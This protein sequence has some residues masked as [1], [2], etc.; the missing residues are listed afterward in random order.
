MGLPRPEIDNKMTGIGT[1]RDFDNSRLD[2]KGGDLFL[3]R[4]E[5]RVFVEDLHSRLKKAEA[6]FLV[7]YKGLDVE[8]MNSIR[9]ELR[10]HNTDFKVIKNRL[11]KLASRETESAILEKYFS[12]PN[13]L[14]I[15]YEDAVAPAKV[16]VEG[17][18]EEKHLE[19]KAG[20]IGGKIMSVDAINRLAELPG[21]DELVAQVL[22]AM[23]AVPASL[24]RVLNG[25]LVQLMN[26][27]KAIE[28]EK[29]EVQ[30]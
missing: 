29:A 18:K 10:K 15:A 30:G 17:M 2:H 5:K 28:G 23:Q 19:I 13:A 14:A 4:E 11:L 20:Q 24:V 12:G 25:V 7:D 27:L 21:R 8:S 16:L 6:T 1:P 22:S 3:N 9:R 26:V